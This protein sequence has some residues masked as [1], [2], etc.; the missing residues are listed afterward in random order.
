MTFASLSGPTLTVVVALWS[1]VWPVRADT[2]FAQLQLPPGEHATDRP[3]LLRGIPQKESY[4][5]YDPGTGRHFDLK[6]LWLRGDLRVRAEW[7]NGVCFGGGAPVGGACNVLDPTGGGTRAHHGRSASDLYVQQWV[8]LGIGYD[9]SPDVNFYF[10]LIDSATWGANGNPAGPDGDAQGHA[11]SA[12]VSGACRLGV[13]AAYAL[14]RNVAGIQGFSLKIGRQYLVFGNQ[15]LFGHFDWANTG[16]SHDGVMVQYAARAMDTYLG[17]F[18]HSESDLGQAAPLGSLNGNVSAVARPSGPDAGADVDMVVLYNQIKTVPGFL[19]E[20]YYV[21]Y[22]NDQREDVNPGLFRPKASS[23]IR[24]MV[25]GRIEMRK[26]NWDFVQETAFQFGRRADG[27]GTD[28]RRNLRIRAWASGT[29]LGYTWYELRWKPRLAVGFD[30]ASGDGDA[31]CVTADG[32]QTRSC[33]GTASTFE[34]FFPTNFL[35]VGYMLNGA[36][37]NIM[38]PQVNVQARPTARDHVEIWAQRKFLA[39]PRDNWYRGSQDP[40]VFSRADN[41]ERRV[42][43]EID[44]AWTRVWADGKVSF[45]VTYGHFFAGP[46]VARNLGT[47]SD[48]DW[49]IMQIW[50]NF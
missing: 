32:V 38:Q 37:R 22:R 30:Y 13:R 23:Q 1:A 6:N 7:R 29:W 44:I 21:L 46:Y 19:I 39:D 24:H 45:T 5:P 40:L 48:Q 11:C 50:A 35:H 43:D 34:N 47:S 25:G 2:A 14:V 28:N 16:Y 42:G 41:T 8:R 10:E 3:D 20:P 27:A 18:R 26:G 31:N 17:W 49:A 12:V 36:W 9:L 33:S 15:R 4:E